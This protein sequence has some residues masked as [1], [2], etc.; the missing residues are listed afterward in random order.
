MT[1]WIVGGGDALVPWG[2]SSFTACVAIGSV[3]ISITSRTRSTSING[4][5]LSCGSAFRDGPCIW[6]S[7]LFGQRG[8][9]ACRVLEGADMYAE[10]RY[11][12]ISLEAETLLT[13]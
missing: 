9:V 1:I 7:S 12:D 4:V 13:E 5:A 10:R 2:I 3:K 8:R 11:K 6:F